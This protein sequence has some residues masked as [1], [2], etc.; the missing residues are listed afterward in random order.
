[1]ETSDWSRTF[2]FGFEPR[3]VT[4]HLFFITALFFLFGFVLF[5]K[6]PVI[7]KLASLRSRAT[8]ICGRREE[9]KQ[10]PKNISTARSFQEVETPSGR[11]SRCHSSAIPELSSVGCAANASC[12]QTPAML[13]QRSE[14]KLAGCFNGDITSFGEG[15]KIMA[16]CAEFGTQTIISCPPF[17]FFLFFLLLSS[18]NKSSLAWRLFIFSSSC[19]P[20][21][22]LGYPG[23]TPRWLQVQVTEQQSDRLH[24][25]AS[26]IYQAIDCAVA[27]LVRPRSLSEDFIVCVAGFCGRPAARKSERDLE[28]RAL[29]AAKNKQTNKERN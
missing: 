23:R 5:Y 21:G 25:L 18:M 11:R 27:P 10:S 8:I 24:R 13:H 28:R 6:L 22:K 20:S 14:N 2:C 12:G 15:R 7:S 3:L 17:F 26:A 16:S 9:R 1:M 4:K 19:P 29:L